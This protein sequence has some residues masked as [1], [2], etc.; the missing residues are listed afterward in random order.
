[1]KRLA[2]QQQHRSGLVLIVVT[3]AVILL[4]MAAWSY[5]SRML[6]E[7]E[8]TA[9]GSRAVAARMAAESGIEFA[10]TRVLERDLEEDVN[11]YHDPDVFQAQLITDGSG[12]RGRLRFSL[13]VPDETNSTV[14]GI[15]FGLASEN[16]KFNVNRLIDLDAYDELSEG[17]VYEVLSVIPGMTEEISDSLRDALDSD[18]ERRPFGAE[19]AD[20]ESM[21]IFD[22]IPNGP[23]ESIDQ[24]LQI[25]GVTPALFYGEDANR[26]GL[27]DPNEN[28]GDELAPPDNAD[29]I[30]DIGWRAYLT[31]TSRERNTTPEGDPKINL[32]QG[33][34]TELYDAVEEQLGTEAAS[35]IVAY[36]LNGTEYAQQAFTQPELGITDDVTRNEIDLR[37]VPSWQFTSVFE[38]IGGVTNPVKMASGVD[39]QFESPWSDDVST[40]LNTL[41]DLEVLFTTTDEPWIEGRININQARVEVLQ[42]IPSIPASAPDSIIAARPVVDLQ[43]ASANIMARRKT[44]AW[45]VV[46]DIVDLETLRTIGPWVTIGG[47]VFSVQS[48]GHYDRGGPTVRLEAHIDGTDFPPAVSFVRSLTHLGR[49]FHPFQLNQDSE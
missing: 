48:I 11:V 31:A 25:Q 15:R 44:A 37:V 9:M 24:L 42:A 46:E 27:L 1:M 38:L 30:L 2:L 47:D 49:G 13:V 5:S 8:A 14:G 35:F 40:L 33:M 28:D 36:R 23:F 12:P 41:P 20:Y 29:G 3:V 17:I 16:A 45:L 19:L 34:M 4:T 43:G 10:A 26:N 7:M 39:R 18:D 32:N 21:G 6:T 22:A